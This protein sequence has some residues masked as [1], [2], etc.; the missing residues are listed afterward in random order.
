MASDVPS[1]NTVGPASR[2]QKRVFRAQNMPIEW[3]KEILIQYLQHLF[4]C[5]DFQ[6]NSLCKHPANYS[7][8]TLVTFNSTIP[9]ILSALDTKP[10]G[11]VQ[12]DDDFKIIFT[13]CHGLTTLFEPS[14]GQTAEAEQV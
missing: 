7:S 9:E 11:H 4:A 6:I 8:T 14:R 5:Q 2:T 12:S 3:N 10:D 1:P 13:H